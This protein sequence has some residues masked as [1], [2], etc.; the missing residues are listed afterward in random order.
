M[1]ETFIASGSEKGQ[2]CVPEFPLAS[3]AIIDADG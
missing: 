2:D 3:S 1:I